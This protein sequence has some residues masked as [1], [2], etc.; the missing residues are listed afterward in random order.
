MPDGGGDAAPDVLGDVGS[1]VAAA[2]M[3]C[4]QS[5]DCPAR[6]FCGPVSKTCISAVVQVVAGAQHSCALHAN[7][8]VSCWGLA[9]AI[10][11]G[12]A[13]VLR[14]ARLSQIDHPLVLSAGTRLT[15]AITAQ[16]RVQCW[17]NQ[18]LQVAREDGMPIGEATALG[19]GADFG[20]AVT[21][22]GTRCWGKNDFGQLARPLD[23]KDSA[24]ALLSR[25]APD[26][27][28]AAAFVGT[29]IAVVSIRGSEL[30]AWGRNATRLVSA[31]EDLGVQ[32]TPQCRSI[33]DVTQ[34]AMGDTHA[35]LLHSDGAFTCWG[36]RYYGQLGLG[37]VDTADVAAPGSKTTLPGGGKVAHLVAGVSHTCAL[38][39]NDAVTCFGRNNLGQVGPGAATSEEEVRAPAPVTGFAGKV[40]A[41]GSGSTAQH[42]CAIIADGQVQ[43]WGSN[44]AGQLGDGVTDLDPTRRS[45]G[46]VTV[47]F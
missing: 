15:C 14:P 47:G 22:E 37:G 3:P 34:L 35:C 43:C 12:G 42:T 46:P 6:S 32:S 36:E 27:A 30:C 18:E 40:I 24:A 26:G 2:A 1:D 31:A 29:G 5:Q 39:S 44:G 7:G 9:E 13:A 8:Q 41:L 19:V 25:A 4:Q 23:V 38:L 10:R 16:R 33:A 45:A 11:A 28:G 21:P 20:C 17:G